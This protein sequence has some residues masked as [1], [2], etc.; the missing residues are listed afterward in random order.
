MDVGI[1]IEIF[2]NLQVDSYLSL[3]TFYR[4]SNWNFFLEVRDFSIAF[5]KFCSNADTPPPN[6]V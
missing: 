1:Q 6:L 4:V 5:L 3:D 2:Q